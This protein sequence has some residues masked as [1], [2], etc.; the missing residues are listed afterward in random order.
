MNPAITVLKAHLAKLEAREQFES[1]DDKAAHI[2][3]IIQF[4]D[5]IA[6]LE[7]CEKYRI[8]G[9]SLISQL[10]ETPSIEHQFVVAYQNESTNSENWEEVLF[11][12]RQVWFSSGDLVIRK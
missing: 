1:I 2:G 3:E 4:K 6:Q 8:T 11:N 12:G 9:G 7:L 10:P 5:S